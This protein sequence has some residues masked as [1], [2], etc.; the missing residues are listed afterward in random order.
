MLLFAQ[1]GAGQLVENRFSEPQP[2]DVVAAYSVKTP[3]GL[4]TI[5]FN[6]HA[7]A[8][9]RV[10]IDPGQRAERATVLQLAAA[11]LDATSGVTLGGSP[12][13]PHGEWAA[14]D[15]TSLR[16]KDGKF[17]VNLPGPSAALISFAE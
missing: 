5:L 13:N 9:V 14:S 11:G 17:T 16:P 7:D 12:V 8:A 2:E 1:A 6:K 15:Q 4:K 10:V 3:S